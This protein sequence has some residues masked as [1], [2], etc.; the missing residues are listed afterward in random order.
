M[1]AF[2]SLS[3]L[4]HSCAGCNSYVHR[5]QIL[6]SIEVW[7]TCPGTM[8]RHRVWLHCPACAPEL[9]AL[10]RSSLSGAV[11]GVGVV[12]RAFCDAIPSLGRIQAISALRV[13]DTLWPL[14][15]GPS[16]WK[17]GCV[18]GRYWSPSDGCIWSLWTLFYRTA[19]SRMSFECW[20]L[21]R[22]DY[23]IGLAEFG[24]CLREQVGHTFW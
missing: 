9:L 20:P 16:A 22:S 19:K 8:V 10:Y 23:I 14:F 24:D 13:Y 4:F 5:L 7:R 18:F 3:I 2:L 15:S 17:D 12:L 21:T 6:V 11:L 1:E